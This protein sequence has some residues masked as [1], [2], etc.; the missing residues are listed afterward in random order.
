MGT[1]RHFPHSAVWL[2]HLHA[3]VV[4]VAPDAHRVVKIDTSRDDKRIRRRSGQPGTGRA[5]IDHEFFAAVADAIDANGSDVLI[6]G[7]GTAKLDFR[8]WLV[9]HR[10]TVAVRIAGVETVDHPSE[11]ELVA[12]CRR[13]FRRR[14]QLA[15]R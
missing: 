13:E 12:F 6:A 9:E 8:R 15:G 14:D 4:L 11:G 10:P 2:D 7:P 5:P 1:N 3:V